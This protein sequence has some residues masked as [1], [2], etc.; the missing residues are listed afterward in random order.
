MTA[1]NAIVAVAVLIAAA[2]GVAVFIERG[3]SAPASSPGAGS[4]HLAASFELPGL[5]PGEPDVS[6]AASAGKPTVV[7]FFAAWC[8]PCKDELPALRDAAATHI[9]ITF[10]GIDHQDSRDDAVQML[11]KFGVNYSAGY[12]PSGDVAARYALRGLP[13]TAFIDAKGGLV[14]LHQGALTAQALELALQRLTLRSA[15]A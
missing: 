2:V 7:N 6:L 15:P 1:R 3:P 9:A 14:E 13:A 10:V 8:E 12:D 5:R 4:L 11:E